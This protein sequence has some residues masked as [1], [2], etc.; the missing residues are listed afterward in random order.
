MYKSNVISLIGYILKQAAYS[1]V[2]ASLLL[3]ALWA[4]CVNSVKARSPVRI[5]IKRF[6]KLFMTLG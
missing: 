4:G 5:A 3:P 6:L 2:F 1:A